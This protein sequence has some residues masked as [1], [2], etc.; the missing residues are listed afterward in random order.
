MLKR[1]ALTLVWLVIGLFGT[2]AMFLVGALIIGSQVPVRI[3]IGGM[4]VDGAWDQG[5][6]STEGT[7]TIEGAQQAFPLQF[8][9]I[10]CFKQ[11]GHCTSSQAEITHGGTLDLFVEQFEITKWDKTTLAFV[12]NSPVCM[13]YVYTIDRSTRRTFGTRKPKKDAPEHCKQML[14]QRDLKLTLVNG[15]TVWQQLH[16]DASARIMPFVWCTIALWWA[17]MFYG[18]V[19]MWRS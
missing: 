12:N 7:W 6:V 10:R 5:Y 14:D 13:D 11:Y 18:I 1:V 3:A 2:V 17:I 9:V 4:V 15:F 8:T 16:A 19:R